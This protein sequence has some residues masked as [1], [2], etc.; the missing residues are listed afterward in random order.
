MGKETK[1]KSKLPPALTTE[2]REAQLINLAMNQAQRQLEE[3]TASSQV[4]T[5]FLKLGV[6]LAQ[7]EKKRL[8]ADIAMRTEKAETLK[9]QRNSEHLLQEALKAFTEYRGESDKDPDDY[10][11]YYE[12]LR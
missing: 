4:L 9:S 1:K 8:E 3:G 11:D 5:F 10:G 6:S 7:L 12:D 2:G